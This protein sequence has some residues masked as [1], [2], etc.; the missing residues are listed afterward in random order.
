MI[1]VVVGPTGIGKTKLSIA[2]AKHFKTEIIS[3]DSVQVYKELNIGSAKVTKE[4]MDGITH[5]LIDILE[6]TEDF[7]VAL[8][9]SLVREDIRN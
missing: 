6:P 9:Q 1:Y 7:S 2:L 5:H 4:E 8:F 3:G